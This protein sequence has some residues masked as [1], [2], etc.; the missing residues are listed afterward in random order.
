MQSLSPEQQKAFQACASLRPSPPN[1]R[2][3]PNAAA[4]T[5]FRDCMTKNGAEIAQNTRMND[6]KTTD[7]KVAKALKTC[8][9]LLP[10]RGS[11]AP[12]PS[13]S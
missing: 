8:Q 12:S 5:A 7:P 4:M 6:L 3:G 11:A 10:Q 9:A 13:S 2:G 1:G